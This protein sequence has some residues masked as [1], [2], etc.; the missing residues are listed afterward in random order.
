MYQVIETEVNMS[1][2]LRFMLIGVRVGLCFISA[3]ALGTIGSNSYSVIIFV[4][5]LDFGLF[6]AFL[7]KKNLPL[8][9][10]STII[11]CSYPNT[12]LA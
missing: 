8:A 2:V 7:M 3:V 4:T 5:S 9:D 6:K 1:S 12:L 11:H 10:L